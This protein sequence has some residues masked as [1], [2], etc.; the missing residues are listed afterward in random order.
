MDDDVKTSEE[1]LSMTVKV[2]AIAGLIGVVVIVFIVV[3]SLFAPPKPDAAET[4]K[5]TDEP[6][7]TAQE[8]VTDD[9]VSWIDVEG[10]NYPYRFSVPETLP[11]SQF[12]DPTAESWGIPWNGAPAQHMILLT[13]ADLSEDPGAVDYIGP[14]KEAFAQNW[15]TNFGGL[16]GVGVFEPFTNSNGLT[17]YW[18]KFTN[19]AGETPNDDIFF[20]IPDHPE[21][22]IRVANGIIDEATFKKIVDSVEWGEELK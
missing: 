22:V 13:V 20:E 12:G 9:S 8:F 2:G 16:T 15:W 21:L 7:V 17:G 5:P 11:L 18:A 6:E 3:N 10:A 19:G 14:S 4:P 1:E